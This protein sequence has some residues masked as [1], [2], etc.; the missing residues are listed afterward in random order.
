MAPSLNPASR[1]TSSSEYWSN[2]ARISSHAA[3]PSRSS[4]A[5]MSAM[6]FV[7]S[8][9]AVFP[10]SCSASS[11]G[12]RSGWAWASAMVMRTP[13]TYTSPLGFPMA[14]VRSGIPNRSQ[15][16]SVRSWDR[17]MR[18]PR[19]HDLTLRYCER[20]GM[21]LRTFA[22]GNPNG[23]VY[24][25]GVRMTMAEAQAHPERLPF[26]LA[27]HEQGKT[28]DELW[29]N[30]IADIKALLDSDGPAAW[31]EIRPTPSRK[32]SCSRATSSST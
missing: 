32:T 30:A 12:S 13:P 20:F 1:R 5:L 9:S 27:E 28:A 18:I 25:G 11:N 10:C 17:G 24:V 8:S 14:N 16:L 26:E 23:L 29:T 19:S 6:A 22:M 4:S 15:Y 7:H 31:E 2:R 21:P 3:G